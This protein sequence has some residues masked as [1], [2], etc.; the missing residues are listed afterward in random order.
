M[1]DDLWTP[2]IR[3]CLPAVRQAGMGKRAHHSIT[4]AARTALGKGA[5]DLAVEAAC[6]AWAAPGSQGEGTGLA[7]TVLVGSPAVAACQDGTAQ[8]QAHITQSHQHTEAW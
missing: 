5:V 1:A 7:E 3:C 2:K 6:Q 8:E 4:V